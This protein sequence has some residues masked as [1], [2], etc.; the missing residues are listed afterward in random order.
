MRASLYFCA[1][2]TAVFLAFPACASAYVLSPFASCKWHVV[3]SPNPLS[4][5][6]YLGF[7]SATSKTDAWA[8]GNATGSATITLA[9]HWNGSAWSISPTVNP[10]GLADFFNAG[11]AIVPNDVWAVGGTYN[12][13]SG[14]FQTLAEHWN[15][16]SW[17][18]V[19]TPNVSAENNQFYAVAADRA[20]DVW[21]VGISR[22]PQSVRAVLIEHWNGSKWKIVSSPAKG[23]GDE[24][25]GS[26]LAFAPNSV[27]ANGGYN[28][29]V[30]QTLAEKWNGTKWKITA[31]PNVNTNSN[32]FNGIAGVSPTDIWSLGDYYNGTVFNSLAEHWNGST[33]TIVPSADMGTNFTAITGGAEVNS[34]DV[35]AVG[36][37]SNGSANFPYTMNWNGSAW[38]SVNSPAIGP[39]GGIFAGASAIPGTTDAWAV[40]VY[41]NADASPH[42]TLIEKFHC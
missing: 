41:D 4:D 19:S 1:A 17:T 32:V 25:L 16:T 21:A 9:E 12:S 37:W 39:N 14:L 22:V 27:F 6:N 28:G 36:L 7:V 35:W 20:N 33:W 3:T 24:V 8:F 2:F 40:G 34:N 38:S 18:V 29:P 26:V 42:L 11:V 30:F 15:G 5:Q 23:T 13:S 10:S 31:T